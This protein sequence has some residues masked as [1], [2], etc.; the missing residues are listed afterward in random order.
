M[1]YA[2]VMNCVIVL[3]LHEFVL[4]LIDLSHLK[5]LGNNFEEIS[6]VLRLYLYQIFSTK[7][8]TNTHF[9]DLGVSERC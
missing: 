5:N 4:D 3:I 8:V 6:E 2:L 9:F 1:F 7:N